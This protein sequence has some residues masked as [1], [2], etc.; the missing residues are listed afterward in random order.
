MIGASLKIVTITVCSAGVAAAGRHGTTNAISM[1]KSCRESR[2]KCNLQEKEDVMR[3][4]YAS[5]LSVGFTVTQAMASGSGE[6]DGVGI[7][8]MLFIAF[9][10]L[11]LLF[12][13]VPGV[14]LFGGMLKGLF[15]TV[16]NK[17]RQEARS[18]IRLS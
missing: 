5:I 11:I 15:T 4:L 1:G 6:G 12:Q 18:T 3:T 7:V 17:T 16:G 14:V 13:L 8:A 10:V 2:L 9:G